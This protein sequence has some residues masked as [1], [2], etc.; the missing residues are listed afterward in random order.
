MCIVLKPKRQIYYYKGV[1]RIM[2]LIDLK[3]IEK[4]GNVNLED[5]SNRGI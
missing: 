4:N 2:R 3:Y 5:L 1:C